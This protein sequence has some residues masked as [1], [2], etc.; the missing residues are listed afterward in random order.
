M[1]VTPGQIRAEHEAAVASFTP[2][3]L[4]A[5]DRMNQAER[6]GAFSLATRTLRLEAVFE[7]EA[8]RRTMGQESE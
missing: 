6:L 4:R 3:Q 2:A 7:A 5:I 8:L 1:H